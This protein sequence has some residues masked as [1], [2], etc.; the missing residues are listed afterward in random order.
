MD[1]LQELTDKILRE[2][3]EKG[4]AEA[5]RIIAEAQAQA[6]K[7][8]AEAKE[9]AE[10]LLT[11]AQKQAAETEQNTKNELKLYTAQALSALKSEVTNL[12]TG[13]LATQ[14]VDKMVADDQFL[15]QMAVAMA[16]A[17]TDETP[18]ITTENAEKLKAY[19][20]QNA[21][22]LLDK[23][24]TIEQVNGHQALF[25][26]APTDGSYKVQFGKD[27]FETYF[28]NFLRPQLVDML[29]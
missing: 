29:F 17:W 25:T 16:S 12:L 15:G 18:V 11:Q 19:F 21:K 5:E 8:Q 4:K 23:G 1:K 27:E 22:A 2:G 13:K 26:I 20:A 9:Q 14:A 10:A 28:K 6:S 7:I 3:V 24:L